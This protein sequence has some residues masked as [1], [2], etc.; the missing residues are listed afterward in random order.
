[1]FYCFINNTNIIIK[2]I[3]NFPK[4]ILSSSHSMPFY[5]LVI[6]ITIIKI[7]IN[8]KFKLNKYN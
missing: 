7:I 4:I 1:M 6:T 8:N 2:H 3:N 5:F